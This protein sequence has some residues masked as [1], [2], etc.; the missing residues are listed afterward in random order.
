MTCCTHTNN[1]N[2]HC[3]NIKNVILAFNQY[4]IV[5]HPALSLN[6]SYRRPR[7]S[8]TI[9]IDRLII[10]PKSAHRGGRSKAL[11]ASKLKPCQNIFNRCTIKQVLSFLQFLLPSF[12]APSLHNLPLF[13]V[14]EGMYVNRLK[15]IQSC[16]DLVVFQALLLSTE[17]IFMYLYLSIFLILVCQQLFPSS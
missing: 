6:I 14:T 7:A 12:D 16:W 1:S 13:P 8:E 11:A 10:L 5:R 2:L 15:E 3:M 4:R 17:L 9:S